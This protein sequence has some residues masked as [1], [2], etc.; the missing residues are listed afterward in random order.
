MD[1]MQYLTK[2]SLSALM[3]AFHKIS[4]K[5]LPIMLFGAGLPQL[6]KLAGEAKTY[7]E[8]LFDYPEIGSLDAKSA[9]AA[10]LEPAERESVTYEEDALNL[11]LKETEGYPF[12]LLLWGDCVWSVAPSSPGESFFK[13]R[14][15]RLT[16]RQQ[17]YARVIAEL[18]PEPA[19]STAVANELGLT[20][21]QAAPIRDEL[22]KKGVAY[23]P[24]RG[25]V[26]FTVPKFDE[27]IKRK[28]PQANA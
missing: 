11:I 22:I 23:S 6:A 3:M 14:L 7:S 18:G 12:F 1:E 8:R 28:I 26:T 24:I 25:R 19:R 2:D 5:A 13:V 16:D 20:V 15:G 21:Q 9:R 17:Q 4:Q 10:L 27:F